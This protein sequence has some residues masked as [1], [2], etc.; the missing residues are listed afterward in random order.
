MDGHRYAD[1]PEPTWYSGGGQYARSTSS[2]VS[3][4]IPA[5]TPYDSGIHER[6]SGAFRLPEQRPAAPAYD[7]VTTSGSHARTAEPEPRIPVRGPE[8]PTIRPTSD[9]VAPPAEARG[10]VAQPTTL[11]PPVQPKKDPDPV[12]QGR[13]PVSSLLVALVTLVLMIPVVRLLLEATFTADPTPRAV[14]PAVL[15]TLGFTL[16]GIGLFSVARGGPVTRDTWLRPP[17]AYLPVGLVL[18][19]AAGLA[20]A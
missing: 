6:P 1:D 14:V 11:V 10:A 5:A 4:S 7:P 9:P 3:G 19:L 2:E 13:R 18:L 20:V 17:A 15:L 12:Y 8:Y 16:A